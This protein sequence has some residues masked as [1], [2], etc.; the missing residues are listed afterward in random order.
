MS[1][2]TAAGIGLDQLRRDVRELLAGT[3][4]RQVITA[5]AGNRPGVEAG[6]LDVYRRLGERGWLAPHWPARYGGQDLDPR[7]AAVITEELTLAGVPDDV[8]VLSIDIVGTFLLLRGSPEQQGR[9]L[10]GFARGESSAC[11]LFS[12][13]HAG[14]DLAALR[15]RAEPDGDGWR[16][17]GSKVWN[18]KS[19]F[20]D[21]ALCAARTST[22]AVP[23]HGITLFLVPMRSPGVHIE[24]V[25]SMPNDRFN[26][27][28]L[29]GL[30]VTAADVVGTADDGWWLIDDLLQLERTGIDFHGKARRLLDL[31][32]GRA[33][34]TGKLSDPA[35]AIPLAELDARLKAGRAMS[36]QMVEKL[37]AGA[38]D[39]VAAA[40]TKWYIC[41]QF[42]PILRAGLDID[43]PAATLTSWDGEAPELGLLEA[44]YRLGPA[45]RLASGTS[46]VMLYLVATNGL[47][48]L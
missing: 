16:L 36:W 32:I 34:A 13:P 10:P 29:D 39:P 40:M 44:N 20:A 45:H 21:V 41:E 7:S 33:A 37:A 3:G 26:L 12:E 8:H 2:A 15:T 42:P 47:G 1:L 9:Y 23:L 43:G 18:M 5:L 48:L 31:V 27:V 14:S 28:V 22:G 24:P 30:R 4:T 46:E 11:V 17:Y 35:Y 6:R 38:P 19:Q 25:P